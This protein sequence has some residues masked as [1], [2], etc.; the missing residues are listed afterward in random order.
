MAILNER[1]KIGLEQLKYFCTEPNDDD[2]S[3]V[4]ARFS[5]SV[6]NIGSFPYADPNYHTAEDKPEFVDLLNVK[7]ATQLSLAFIIFM[8]LSGSI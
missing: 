3:F 5:A 7:L 8:D 6:L 2:G 1:Y 4:K